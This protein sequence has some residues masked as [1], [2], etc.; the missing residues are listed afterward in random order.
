MDKHSLRKET[1]RA[2]RA[3]PPAM[4]QQKSDAIRTHL[5]Q[6]EAYRTARFIFTYISM[7]NEADTLG[8]IAAAFADGKQVAVPVC[9]AAGQMDFV[10]LTPQT[11]LHQ[12]AHGTQEPTYDPQAVLHPSAGDLFLVPGLVFDCAGNRCGY[13]GG[14]YDRYLAAHP[15]AVPIALCFT[16]QISAQVLAVQAHD[17]PMAQLLCEDGWHQCGR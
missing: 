13:G 4:W 3:L 16:L 9:G 8:I 7:Q 14:F 2:R 10:R 15:A 17:V 1:Q 6:S 5:L 11:P 12:T